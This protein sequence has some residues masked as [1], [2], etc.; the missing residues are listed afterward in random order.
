MP[1]SQNNLRAYATIVFWFATFD[2][3]PFAR[4]DRFVDF[5]HCDHALLYV[6]VANAGWFAVCIMTVGLSMSFI[7]PGLLCKP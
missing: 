7:S 5:C 4:H 3:E 1:L 6:H 2:G